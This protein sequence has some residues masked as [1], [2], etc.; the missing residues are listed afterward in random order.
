MIASER[1]GNFD[2]IRLVAAI[3]VILGH[4][5]SIAG[6]HSS[7]FFDAQLHQVAIAAVEV[8]FILSG[9]LVT[10][11]FERSRSW[12]RFVLARSLRI[13]PGLVACILV[14]AIASVTCLPS[15][16]CCLR[17]LLWPEDKSLLGSRPGSVLCARA[18]RATAGWRLRM[19]PAVNHSAVLTGTTT[20]SRG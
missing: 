20:D 14:S 8:F 12:L 16:V 1:R 18:Y 11:R 13:F 17:R 6:A 9:Y 5:E 4:S 7:D 3:G 15:L 2:A 10:L 19:S